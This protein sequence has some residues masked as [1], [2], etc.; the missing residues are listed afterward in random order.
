M[1]QPQPP[2][3]PP[4]DCAALAPTNAPA[5]ASRGHWG[6]RAALTGVAACGAGALVGGLNYQALPGAEQLDWGRMP[7]A[8]AMFAIMSGAALGIC[9]GGGL[10]VAARRQAGLLG[11]MLAG[12]LGG[13]LAGVTPGVLGIAGFGS[14]SAPYAGTANILGSTLLGAIV[15]VALWSPQLYPRHDRLAS[16]VVRSTIASVISLGGFGLVAWS[17]ALR[18]DL[19]PNFDTMVALAK[20]VGLLPLSIAI[21]AAMGAG[22]GSVIGAACGLVGRMQSR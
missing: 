22:L 16:H 8:I 15:F 21:G 2:H 12:A 3:N 17:I 18:Q 14:L 6:I 9:I 1:S 13:L 20:C 7:W 4:T 19:L 5:I 11:S 10:L